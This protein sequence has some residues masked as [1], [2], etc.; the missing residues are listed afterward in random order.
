M[1]GVLV[2]SN[3]LL[4]LLNQDDEW[5]DWSAHAVEQAAAS[6]IVLINPIIYAEVS[7]RFDSIEELDA[8]LPTEYFERRPLPW[9]AA[10]LAAKCFL[11]YRKRGGHK[12]SPLPDFYIGAHAAVEGLTL[13][14][15]D[16]KRY[17][18][19]FPRLSIIAP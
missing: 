14:T 11:R 13:L 2:D 8:A 10:F 9:D 6:S 16:A 18:R 3:I 12:T 4:D 5:L 7:T 1:P 17:R 19:Y 15:R